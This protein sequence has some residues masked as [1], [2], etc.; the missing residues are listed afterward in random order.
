VS[1]AICQPPVLQSLSTSLRG[2]PI[3]IKN[4]DDLRFAVLLGSPNIEIL[5]QGILEGKSKEMHGEIIR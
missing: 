3:V 4:S 1:T 5:N 2:L